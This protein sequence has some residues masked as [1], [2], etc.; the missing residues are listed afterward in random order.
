[1]NHEILKQ[2]IK[3]QLEVIKET[4]IVE[5]KDYVFEENANYVLVGLRRS[6]K[7]TLLYKRVKDLLAKGVEDSQI[8]YITFEDERLL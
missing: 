5:R 4:Q 7:S 2:V 8:I 1:M 6:G 3:D